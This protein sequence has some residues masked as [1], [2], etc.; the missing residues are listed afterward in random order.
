MC[1]LCL[2]TVAWL[3]VGG[4]STASLAALVAGLLKKR[5]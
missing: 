5:N 2:S 1:T 3:E 4:G